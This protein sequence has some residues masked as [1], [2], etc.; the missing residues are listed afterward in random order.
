MQ[1]KGLGL[2]TL[3]IVP[4]DIW[5]DEWAPVDALSS[6]GTLEILCRLRSQGQT[7]VGYADKHDMVDALDIFPDA[8]AFMLEDTDVAFCLVGKCQ[9]KLHWKHEGN[10]GACITFI[11]STRSRNPRFHSCLSSL[12]FPSATGTDRHCI[13]LVSC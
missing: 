3:R 9:T 7:I 12:I 8:A 2:R 5:P 10:R 1:S 13:V 4:N 11:S 6:L